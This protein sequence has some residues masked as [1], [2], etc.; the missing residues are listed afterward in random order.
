VPVACSQCAP[1][2][3]ENT[4]VQVSV[5]AA[6][7][8]CEP[9]PVG[10]KLSVSVCASEKMHAVAQVQ[11]GLRW[12]SSFDAASCDSRAEVPSLC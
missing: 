2:S 7:C 12:P 8:A 1:L 10:D 11:P 5:S 3:S 6:R 9:A 4:L